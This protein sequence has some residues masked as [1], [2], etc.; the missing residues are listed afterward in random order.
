MVEIFPCDLIQYTLHI[1]EQLSMIWRVN[2]LM[3]MLDDN[4]LE[5]VYF[6]QSDQNISMQNKK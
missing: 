6:L 1:I 3:F 4:D 2:I 5:C